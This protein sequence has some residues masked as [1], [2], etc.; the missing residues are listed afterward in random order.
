M[1]PTLGGRRESRR[2]YLP[3]EGSKR[4]R[5]PSGG[6]ERVQALLRMLHEEGGACLRLYEVWLL[7]S[8]RLFREDGS[9]GDLFEVGFHTGDVGF[10]H[11]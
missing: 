7:L 6:S 4:R 3:V 8:W 2:S 9:W 5:H 10:Q 1:R 11:P